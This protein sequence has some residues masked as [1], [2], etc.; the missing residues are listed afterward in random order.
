M[1]YIDYVPTSDELRLYA[2]RRVKAAY[3]LA[4]ALLPIVGS[5]QAIN[6]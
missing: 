3:A 1:R 2:P 6:L 4:A 5:L